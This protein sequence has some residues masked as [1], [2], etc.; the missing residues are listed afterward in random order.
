MLSKSKFEATNHAGTANRSLFVINS[1]K[2]LGLESKAELAENKNDVNWYR[3]IGFARKQGSGLSISFLFESNLHEK[4]RSITVSL[5]SFGLRTCVPASARRFA[6]RGTSVPLYGEVQ[7]R[8][9]NHYFAKRNLS[10]VDAPFECSAGLSHISRWTPSFAT[11]HERKFPSVDSINMHGNEHRRRGGE[12]GGT[13]SVR[14][15]RFVC[16]T[17][18]Y[19]PLPSRT[20]ALAR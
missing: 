5:S 15:C 2:T 16:S 3:N 14:L 13:A 17:N 10:Q 1:G 11:F 8:P 7:L 19:L 4:G 18:W 6:S 12:G 20:G 9:W